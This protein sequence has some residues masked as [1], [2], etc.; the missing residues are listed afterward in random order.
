MFRDKLKYI[1]KKV[2]LNQKEVE[3]QNRDLMYWDVMY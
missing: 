3:V 2:Y 1:M